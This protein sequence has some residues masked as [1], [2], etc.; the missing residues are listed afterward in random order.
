MLSTAALKLETWVHIITHP[1][2]RPGIWTRHLM[3]LNLSIFLYKV[4]ITITTSQKN[5]GGEIFFN[6]NKVWPGV[7]T[8][9]MKTKSQKLVSADALRASRGAKGNRAGK[10]SK[11]HTLKS[12]ECRVLFYRL[13]SVIEG[14]DWNSD[15][16]HQ[17]DRAAGGIRMSCS[18]LKI[19]QDRWAR[20]PH[21]STSRFKPL[22]RK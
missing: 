19:P 1:Y 14:P 5:W 16:L 2:I 9:W 6:L 22:S 21:I 8:Q 12:H 20:P 3:S 13:W 11:I 17:A 4:E 7:G 15:Y 10:A 18:G